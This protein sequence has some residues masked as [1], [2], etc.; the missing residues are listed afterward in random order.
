MQRNGVARQESVFNAGC[1]FC[2][3]EMV[4]KRTLGDLFCDNVEDM[5]EAQLDVFLVPAADLRIVGSG[6]EEDVELRLGHVLHVIAEKVAQ[7]AL[8]HHFL[9]A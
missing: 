5:A 8:R 3:Q 6:N 1:S 4:T 2:L 7:G 9:H